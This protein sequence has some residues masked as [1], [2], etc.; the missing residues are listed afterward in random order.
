MK[1]AIAVLALLPLACA[2]SADAAPDT[3]KA[4]HADVCKPGGKVLFAIDHRATDGAKL[5][6]YSIKVFGNGAWT[7][8][9]VDAE[10]K[11]AAPTA[12]CLDK[13]YAKDLASSLHAAPWKVTTAQVHCM[14]M[15]PQFI[16]Y[17]VDGKLVFTQKLCSGQNLDD[18]SRAAL[19]AAVAKVEAAA[20]PAP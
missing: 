10:G 16:E 8:Q 5:E 19:D 6:T 3:P 4:P 2:S 1:H 11:A 20:K 12:G 14:A 17:Q 13:A 15:S 9:D 7:R 18:K